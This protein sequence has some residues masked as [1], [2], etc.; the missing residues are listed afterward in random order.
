MMLVSKTYNNSKTLSI[1][2]CRLLGRV[3]DYFG[4]DVIIGSLLC[5]AFGFGVFIVMVLA[6][7]PSF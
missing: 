7:T 5:W 1:R 2:F 6:C 4:V 3:I